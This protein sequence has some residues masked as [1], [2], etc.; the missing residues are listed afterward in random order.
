M[1]A[2]EMGGFVK[3]V[4]NITRK[5]YANNTGIVVIFIEVRFDH[6]LAFAACK[7]MFEMLKCRYNTFRKFDLVF[8]TN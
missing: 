4:D 7:K 5:N 8:I 2:L 3:F 1:Y 6:I